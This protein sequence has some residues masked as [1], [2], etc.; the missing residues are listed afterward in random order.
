M[1]PVTRHK[2][3][4]PDRSVTCTK[5]SLKEAKICA[6]P[7]TSSP[8]RV[9]GPRDTFSSPP[10]FLTLGAILQ[11]DPLKQL[12][13]GSKREAGRRLVTHLELRD[14]DEEGLH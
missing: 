3:S 11:D 5:V 4:L 10:D 2:V 1:P 6:T 7:N 8:S 9:A 14:E 12:R 13:L